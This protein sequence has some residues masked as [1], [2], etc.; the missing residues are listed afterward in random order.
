MPIRRRVAWIL[1]AQHLASMAAFRGYEVDEV[2]EIL[3]RAYP[4]REITR[5]DVHS[6]LGMLAGILSMTGIFRSA[7]YYMTGFT[8]VWRRR[9]QPDACRIRRRYHTG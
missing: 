1:L 8:G 4:F 3:P 5:E 6:V 9:I 2:M 7:G